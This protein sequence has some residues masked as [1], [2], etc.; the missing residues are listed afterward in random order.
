MSFS[1][2]NAINNSTITSILDFKIVSTN[3][4]DNDIIIFNN[5]TWNLYVKIIILY[6]ETTHIIC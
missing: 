2:H 5:N 4:T 1:I 6:T 3:L